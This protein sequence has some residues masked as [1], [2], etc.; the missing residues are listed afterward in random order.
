MRL[1]A[2]EEMKKKKNT[3]NSAFFYRANHI[4]V[5]FR[6]V[7]EMVHGKSLKSF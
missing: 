1:D 4:R 2:K 6:N 5:V 7:L 3:A